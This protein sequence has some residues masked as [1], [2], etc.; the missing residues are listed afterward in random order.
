MQP[1]GQWR[2]RHPQL[3]LFVFIY[4][5]MVMGSSPTKGRLVEDLAVG[6]DDMVTVVQEQL[7]CQVAKHK[8]ALVASSD[9]VLK[10]IAKAFGSFGGEAGPAATNLVVDFRIGRTRRARKTRST[11]SSR[12]QKLQQ[13]C[14]RLRSV[15]AGGA[16]IKNIYKT[17]L[18]Q[19]GYYGHEVNG[20]DDR[21]VWQ[22]QSH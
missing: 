13:R 6:A 16:D 17:G 11:L 18:E 4:D 3:W 14:R 22:A 2:Q 15:R 12:F 10:D 7:H 21:E 8:A 20:M 5:V 1:Y 19:A 9:G